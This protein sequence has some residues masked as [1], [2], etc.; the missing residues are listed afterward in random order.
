MPLRR[1]NAITTSMRS[2]DSISERS[3]LHSAGL[4]GRVGE[5]RRVEQRDER[6]LDRLR[7]CRRGGAGGWR[8]GPGPGRSGSSLRVG[9]DE[10]AEPLEEVAGDLDADGDAVVLA[11]VGERPLDLLA[12]VPSDP[13]RRLG[14]A[15][16]VL[17]GQQPL[18]DLLESGAQS[19]GDK[20]L[21]ES[22]PEVIHAEKL[23]DRRVVWFVAGPESAYSDANRSTDTT[24]QVQVVPTGAERPSASHR[25]DS[26]ARTSLWNAVPSAKRTLA[27]SLKDT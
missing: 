2:A 27:S 18:V 17:L 15:E 3:W 14:A 24:S 19:L 20:A 1:M 11:H 23:R 26:P 7:A 9:R 21:E 8:A 22:G 10:L 13:V 12:Q 16:G 6:L 25:T 5:Q 4:A